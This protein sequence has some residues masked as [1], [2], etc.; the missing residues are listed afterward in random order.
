MRIITVLASLLHR[1][2]GL[3]P[4]LEPLDDDP[5]GD[6][7]TLHRPDVAAL[8]TGLTEHF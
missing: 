5:L 1:L 2:P 8:R 4:Q 7:S 6:A 3:R